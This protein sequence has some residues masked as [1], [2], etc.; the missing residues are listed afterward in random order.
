[1]DRAKFMNEVL[2]NR[3]KACYSKCKNTREIVKLFHSEGR[4][5]YE[6]HQHVSKL[7]STVDAILSNMNLAAAGKFFDEQYVHIPSDQLILRENIQ[8]LVKVCEQVEKE[9]QDIKGYLS[10]P[11]TKSGKRKDGKGSQKDF[12][13]EKITVLTVL[14][15]NIIS[16]IQHLQD[17]ENKCRDMFQGHS[18]KFK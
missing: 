10:S 16:N 7:S 14:R 6:S 2:P 1:M 17:E 4:Y 12:D 13:E 5:Q 11:Y 8:K 3:N 15:G 9:E 18:L